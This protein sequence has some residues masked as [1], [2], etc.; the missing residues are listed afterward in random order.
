MKKKSIKHLSLGKKTV[1]KLNKQEVAGGIGISFFIPCTT[2]GPTTNCGTQIQGCI[3][4]QVCETVEVDR[5]TI[6]IC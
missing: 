3:S 4:M 5:N 2:P 6:P 1:S